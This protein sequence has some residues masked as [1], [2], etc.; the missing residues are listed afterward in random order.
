MGLNAA[1]NSSLGVS[2]YTRPV[3]G[4]D[5]KIAPGI[6]CSRVENRKSTDVNSRRDKFKFEV[7]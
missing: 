3:E 5:P 4:H 6:C 7:N 1:G 2:V